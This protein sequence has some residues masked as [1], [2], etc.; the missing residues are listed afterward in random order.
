[1]TGPSIADLLDELI[2]ALAEG[3][4]E[5]EVFAEAEARRPARAQARRDA[6]VLAERREA[7]EAELSASIARQPAVKIAASLARVA[8]ARDRAGED[9]LLSRL[10][11]RDALRAVVLV[12]AGA[13]DPA[14]IG[15]TA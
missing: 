1:M 2:S 10:R 3:L 14:R 6:E 8:S 9:A 5:P 13:A 11:T 4:C 7:K 15:E 12:L